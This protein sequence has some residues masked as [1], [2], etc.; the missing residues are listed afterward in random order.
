MRRDGVN[1]RGRTKLPLRPELVLAA[2]SARR[3]LTRLVWALLIDHASQLTSTYFHDGR[4]NLV[5]IYGPKPA[6]FTWDARNRLTQAVLPTSTRYY[7]YDSDGELVY[8]AEGGQ[9]TWYVRDGLNVVMELNGARIP[10]AQIVPGVAKIR[11]DLPEPQTEYFL[12]DGLGSVVQLTDEQGN[13]TQEYF[14]EPFGA[15]QYAPRKDPFN[16]YR[17]VGLASD[18]A[19]GLIYMNA[20]WYDPGMGRF[21]SRDQVAGQSTRP[22]S[23][24][25]YAYAGDNPQAFTD[26]S[27]LCSIAVH[28]NPIMITAGIALHAVIYASDYDATHSFEGGKSPDGTNDCIHNP[29]DAEPARDDQTI[30]PLDESGAVSCESYVDYFDSTGNDV[31]ARRVP[32]SAMSANS[33]SLAYTLLLGAGLSTAGAPGGSVGWG[34]S[35]R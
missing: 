9:G 13:L 2:S 7:S 15:Q 14:Y 28:F 19:T 20:R 10:T 22:Q 32:Y 21:S 16:R 4:G 35:L 6:A 11:L 30:V 12:H 31:L 23:L 33:N 18:D 34:N 1:L 27:G 5:G 26:S 3:H 24:N 17:F 25:L 29:S 8:E